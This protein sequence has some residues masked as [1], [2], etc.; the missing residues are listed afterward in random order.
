MVENPEVVVLREDI[1]RIRA[2]DNFEGNF[3]L[4]SQA[5]FLEG[6]L[7]QMPDRVVDEYVADEM[8]RDDAVGDD[9]IFC[10]AHLMSIDITR[11]DAICAI[12]CL[13]DD[14]LYRYLNGAWRLYHGKD[15]VP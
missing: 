13:E 1:A 5:E 12:N 4:R 2:S 7:A 8:D 6:Q 14:D 11:P 15:K 10:R 3:L 9:S